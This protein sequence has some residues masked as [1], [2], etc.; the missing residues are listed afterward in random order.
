MFKV[1]FFL[2]IPGFIFSQIP[3]SSF[4]NWTDGYP[5]GWLTTSSPL[6]VTVTKS[7][8]AHDG[9]SALKGEVIN[10]LNIFPYGAWIFSDNFPVSERYT[11]VKGYIK[12]S[13]Q[14]DQDT[15]FG[16]V[17]V[18]SQD[19]SVSIGVGFVEITQASANYVQFEIPIGYYSELAPGYMNLLFTNSSIDTSDGLMTIGSNFILDHLTLSSITGLE[20]EINTAPKGFLLEQNYPNPFNP[21]TKIRY[22]IPE[23]AYVKLVVFDNMGHEIRTLVNQNQLAGNYIVNFNAANLASGTYFYRIEAGEFIQSRRMLVIK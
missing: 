16:S 12:F 7:N 14:T 17:W 22:G 13:P 4:E 5:D 23:N 11:S 3:N 1:I 10:Y 9:S 20:R 18:Q 21:Q 2:I 19:T 6:A 8:D 15:F